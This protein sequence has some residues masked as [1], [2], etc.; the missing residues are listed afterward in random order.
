[1]NILTKDEYIKLNERIQIENADLIFIHH[2]ITNDIVK[3]KI[4]EKE[5]NKALVSIPGD[6]DYYGQPNFYIKKTQ[7]IGKA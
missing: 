3:V 7:I 5:Y 4:E 1:M 6:S 2:P